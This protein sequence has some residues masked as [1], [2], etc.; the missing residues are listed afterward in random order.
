[1]KYLVQVTPDIQRANEIEEKNTFGSMISYLNERYKP[2]CIYVNPTQRQL[3]TIVDLANDVDCCE[4][5]LWFSRGA[6][7]N[8][9][10][11]PLVQPAVASKAMES[12]KRSPTF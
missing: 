7:T 4:L 5:S 1:M 3:F 11:T 12:L 6:L 10:F 2:E 9:S 8:P